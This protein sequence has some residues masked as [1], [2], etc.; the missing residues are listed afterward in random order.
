MV[1]LPLGQNKYLDRFLA[2]GE[3]P[4]TE[5]YYL[6]RITKDN[7]WTQVDA[8]TIRGVKYGAPYNNANAV[9]IGMLGKI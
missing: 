3:L 4:F 1:T 8:E 7:R 2:N 9:I 6:Q 5:V